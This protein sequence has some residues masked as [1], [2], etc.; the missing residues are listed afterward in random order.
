M[1]N[2][3]ITDDSP[4]TAPDPR[5]HAY[6]DD[7]A[8]KR[9]EGQVEAA[10]FAPGVT[11][12][13]MRPAVPL[14]R[15]P[16]YTAS[17]DTELLFGEAVTLYDV[18]EGWAWVQALRDGYVGYMPADALTSE[19]SAPT[20]RV[21][22]PGTFVYPVPDMKAPPLMHL[23]LNS[24]LS[25][26]EMGD[27]FCR[28]SSGGFVVTRHISVRSRHARDFV[29]VAELMIGTPYLW[30]GRTRIGLDC[31]GIVQLSLEAAGVAAPR[32]S[33]MQ[34]AELG[35]HIDVPDDLEGLLRGDLIFWPGHVGIMTDGIMLLHANA[36]HMAVVIETLPEAADRIAKSGSAIA[37]IKRVAKPSA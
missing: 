30:G 32:D 13:V 2:T 7:L 11:R 36:H 5:R 26:A 22:A 27:K 25:I 28:L 10:H 1:T 6:R 9:L 34:L 17:L 23:S 12:Q 8:D 3:P 24:Q 15:K 19:V 20:H 14:R 33:E 4:A 16:D 37:A 31:S 18:E 29:E 21:H 35:E